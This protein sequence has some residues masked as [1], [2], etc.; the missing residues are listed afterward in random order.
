MELFDKSTLKSVIFCAALMSA[1]DG[2]VDKEEWS[3]IKQFI[4]DYWA[5]EFGDFKE[6]QTEIA[7]NVKKL[8]QNRVN[9]TNKLNQLVKILGTKLTTKQKQVLLELAK[10]V[11]LADRKISP[12]EEILLDQLIKILDIRPE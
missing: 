2:D 3:V 5:S 12:Q 6:V 8:L 11:M 10:E 4:G 9:M 1:I 7:A